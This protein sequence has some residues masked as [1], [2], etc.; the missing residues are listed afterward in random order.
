MFVFQPQMQGLWVPAYAGT[1]LKM[2]SSAYSSLTLGA[3][4]LLKVSA[5]IAHTSASSRSGDGPSRAPVKLH[6]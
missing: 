4:R 1:T 6:I 3:A 2:K 5:V